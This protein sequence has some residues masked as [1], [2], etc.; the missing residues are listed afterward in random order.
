MGW[1]KE[2]RVSA[3]G[4]ALGKLRQGFPTKGTERDDRM[5]IPRLPE[6]K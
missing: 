5:Q 3:L 6:D 1:A 2:L 4:K